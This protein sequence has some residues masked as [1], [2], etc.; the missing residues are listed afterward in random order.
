ME[1]YQSCRLLAPAQSM[2]RAMDCREMLADARTRPFHLT[3]ISI[4]IAM[5][6]GYVLQPLETPIDGPPSFP[7]SG[8]IAVEILRHTSPCDILS[9]RRV[10]LYRAEDLC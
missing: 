7:L 6:L 3:S 1:R 10:S 2:A 5:A 4:Q 9:M 8:E